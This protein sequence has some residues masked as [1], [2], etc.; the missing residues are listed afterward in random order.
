MGGGL[1]ERGEREMRG[2]ERP[3][4]GMHHRCEP[5]TAVGRIG[6]GLPAH[7][8]PPPLPAPDALLSSAD[9]APDVTA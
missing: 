1:R 5:L 4:G 2:L 9:T 7:R 8:P 6:P 3:G